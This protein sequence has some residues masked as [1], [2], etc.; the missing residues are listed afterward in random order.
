MRETARNLDSL[1]R[2]SADWSHVTNGN[3]W[4]IDRVGW[5]TV[6]RNFQSP[7]FSHPRIFFLLGVCTRVSGR[8]W[9]HSAHKVTGLLL[10]SRPSC[11]LSSRDVS[12]SCASTRVPPIFPSSLSV[13]NWIQTQLQSCSLLDSTDSPIYFGLQSQYCRHLE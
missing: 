3:V 11:C 2:P 6:L 13:L 9:S 5:R 4:A 8:I 7:H 1:A 10:P 12:V